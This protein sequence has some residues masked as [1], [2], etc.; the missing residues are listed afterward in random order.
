MQRL[1]IWYNFIGDTMKQKWIIQSPGKMLELGE[2]IGLTAK[3][4]DV[5]LL[6][7]DLGAGKTTLTKGIGVGLN[8]NSIITSPTFNIL[9]IYEGRL[10]LYHFD[11]YRLENQ[12]FYDL[13]FDE[14]LDQGGVCVIEWPEMVEADMPK[15]HLMIE[16]QHEGD[17]RIVL[18]TGVGQRYEELGRALNENFIA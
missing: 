16:I 3:P 2:K 17:S 18:V 10:T 14:M 15:E 7:G 4:N 11:A 8:I 12:S 9:K 6:T 1:N 13:G 5:Y